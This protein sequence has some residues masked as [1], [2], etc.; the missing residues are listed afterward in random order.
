MISFFVSY[1]IIAYCYANYSSNLISFLFMIDGILTSL[2]F[3]ISSYTINGTANQIL[4]KCESLYTVNVLDR[5]IYYIIISL[6]FYNFNLF[7]WT[8]TNTKD[9]HYIF[10]LFTCPSNVNIFSQIEPFREIIKFI[11]KQIDNILKLICAIQIS[12]IIKDI[13]EQIFHK[14]YEINKY[15][16][17]NAL[18]VDPNLHTSL[19][20]CLKNFFII[21]LLIFLKKKYV[22]I[23]KYCAKLIYVINYGK[24]NYKIDPNVFVK[25]ILEQRKWYLLHDPNTIRI[26]IKLIQDNPDKNI[27]NIIISEIKYEFTKCI[28]IWSLS[29]YLKCIY[30]IPPLFLLCLLFEQ[31][32]KKNKHVELSTIIRKILLIFIL[33]LIGVCMN[34]YILTILICSIS[35]FIKFDIKEIS[36]KK[37]FY[38]IKKTH[39][40]LKGLS[41]ALLLLFIIL[42]KS[43]NFY[44]LSLL[45]CINP[46]ELKILYCILFYIGYLSNYYILHLVYITYIYFIVSDFFFSK[47][48]TYLKNLSNRFFITN[49][50]TPL[51]D[52]YF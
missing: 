14:R 2:L 27:G 10:L 24:T 33:G 23:Y 36:H 12:I 19:G 48:K 42:H 9:L 49:N 39:F 22:Y 11:R 35:V 3:I 32:R 38:F 51:V 13:S 37:I 44:N 7:F 52:N 4:T 8:N 29:T 34:N 18:F 45:L 26:I 16:I 6:F 20:E 43:N 50:H 41:Y 1:G 47:I 21:F 17:Y 30:I 28:S 5:Y 40:T 31:I 25:N 46:I 15:D